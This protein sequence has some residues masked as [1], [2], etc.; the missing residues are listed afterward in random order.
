[1]KRTYQGSCH[2]GRVKFEVDADLDHVRVCDCSMCRRRGALNHRVAEGD[3]RILSPL[4]HV[5]LYQW[6]TMTAKD[7]F[8]PM[9]GIQPFRGP[10]TAPEQWTVNVR[11]LEGID[12][13]A[14]TK[15]YVHG[16]KLDTV[17]GQ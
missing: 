4:A 5:A 9:C 10:R 11:C 13:E 8:C 16:S 7:Y 14:I 12:P 6:N 3:L 15:K 17:N 1:M 2:C